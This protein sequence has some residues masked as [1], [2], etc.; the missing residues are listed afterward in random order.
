LPSV[1]NSKLN[2][3]IIIINMFSRLKQEINTRIKKLK[4]AA[5]LALVGYIYDK[6]TN[7]KNKKKE[8]IEDVEYEI[9]EKPDRK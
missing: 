8:Y 2:L 1:S 5:F 9:K 6:I 4:K 3:K 7:R